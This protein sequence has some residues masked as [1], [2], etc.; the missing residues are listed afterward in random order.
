[1]IIHS[2][3]KIIKVL[4]SLC[5]KVNKQRHNCLH[6]RESWNDTDCK[7]MTGLTKSQIKTIEDKYMSQ[8]F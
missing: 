2:S 6:Q 1:M 4:D 3:D 8:K 7:S 5:N